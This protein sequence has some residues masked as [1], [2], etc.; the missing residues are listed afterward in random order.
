MNDDNSN[1]Q[2]CRI[3][4][5]SK[6]YIGTLLK[7]KKNEKLYYILISEQIK[8]DDIK[9]IIN[10]IYNNKKKEIDLQKRIFED[11]NLYNKKY[12]GIEIKKEDNIN[13]N[14]FYEINDIKNYILEINKNDSINEEKND[15]FDN[16]LKKIDLRRKDEEKKKSNNN[17]N[18]DENNP[19]LEYLYP[20]MEM[21]SIN[22]A[23]KDGI[24]SPNNYIENIQN[25]NINNFNFTDKKSRKFLFLIILLLVFIFSITIIII[26]CSNSKED[27]NQNPKQYS[28]ELVYYSDKD[29]DNITLINSSF[30]EIIV[31]ME[32]N[33]EIVTPCSYY[34]FKKKEIIQY[35]LIFKTIK[36]F[37]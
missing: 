9:N 16:F 15:S 26:I 31:K 11:L 30:I 23:Q 24:D 12:I 19:K 1:Q 7:L 6:E 25:N 32:I 29:N 37:L 28:F 21:D 2:K 36:Q 14:Y 13:E 20:L 18:K 5:N 27:S 33:D 8:K 4:I 10:I 35:I 3:I 34:T 17:Q 22:D